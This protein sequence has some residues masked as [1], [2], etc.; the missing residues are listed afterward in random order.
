MFKSRDIEDKMMK[1][2]TFINQTITSAGGNRLKFEHDREMRGFHP[3]IELNDRTMG[4][5][6]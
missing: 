6:I 1:K 3:S 4:R 2:S 5:S